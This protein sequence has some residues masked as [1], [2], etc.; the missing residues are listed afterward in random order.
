MMKRR[1]MAKA[2]FVDRDGTLN[3]M[4]YDETHGLMDSPRRPAQVEL[5]Q[6]ASLFLKALRA[7]GYLI[8]VVTNQPGIAKGTMTLR[9]LGIVNKRLAALLE[10]EGGRWDALYYCPHHPGSGTKADRVCDCRKPKPGMI[11]RAADEHGIDLSA[12]WMI[13]DGLNDVQ[14]AKAAGCRAILLTRLKLE[15]IERFLSVV[16]GVPDVIAHDFVAALAS[17][18][19]EKPA[20]ASGHGRQGKSRRPAAR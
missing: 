3:H 1:G 18:R 16:D 19:G 14:A 10:R 2:C 5:V 6:G 12:S 8:I 9:E 7:M 15:Q 4:V 17:M 13:G 11:M 20:K